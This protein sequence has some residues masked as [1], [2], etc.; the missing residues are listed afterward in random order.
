M[1][2]SVLVV[3][4]SGTGKSRAIKNLDPK[5]TA[6][7]TPN[8]K[9]LPFAGSG[10]NYKQDVNVFK[11]TTFKGVMDTIKQINTDP[12]AAFIKTLILEDLTHY[13]SKRVMDDGRKEG[14]QKWSDLAIDAFKAIIATETELRPDL[15]MIIIAHVEASIDT[16]GNSVITLLTPGK[17]LDKQI[18]I[19]SYFTYILH[20]V[21]EIK[22]GKATY[23]FLTNTDGIRLAKSPEDCFPQFIDNDY[24]LVLD[25]IEK[26]QGIV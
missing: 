19:P 17:L 21:V 12:A 10:A 14:Y 22:E 6:I 24:K 9:Q 8:N 3:G 16:Y 15:N 20:T 5:T 7:I 4:D 2:F 18:K 23:Q 1:G 25:T 13:F 26:Y 11:E